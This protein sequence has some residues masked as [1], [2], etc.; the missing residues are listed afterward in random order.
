V[1]KEDEEE[2]KEDQEEEVTRPTWTLL[3]WR[4]SY[5]C[6]E[7]IEEG[8][9]GSKEKELLSWERDPRVQIKVT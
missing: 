3:R 8:W 9:K 4:F 7:E 5:G 1:R 6:Q 2:S